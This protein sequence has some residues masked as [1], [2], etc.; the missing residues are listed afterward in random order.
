MLASLML[1]RST[2][3][4]Y[5]AHAT[6][7]ALLGI[8]SLPRRRSPD[9]HARRSLPTLTNRPP[10]PSGEKAKAD[11]QPFNVLELMVVQIGRRDRHSCLKPNGWL[12][13]LCQT[14]FGVEQT[15]RLADP[16]LEALR[17]LVIALGQRHPRPATFKAALTAGITRKQIDFLVAR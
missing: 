5:Q 15:T 10:F 6:A 12:A 9:R 3:T 17:I 7:D 2:S 14:F 11:I 8:S 13:I 16:R 1:L 4:P